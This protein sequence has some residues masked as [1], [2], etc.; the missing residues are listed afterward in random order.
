MN[1]IEHIHQC[2]DTSFGKGAY[3]NYVDTKGGGGVMEMS[4]FVYIGGRGVLSKVYVAFW[5]TFF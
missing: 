2:L 4:T 3:T 5:A 1:T